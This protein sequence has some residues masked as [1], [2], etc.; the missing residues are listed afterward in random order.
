MAPMYFTN[1][2]HLLNYKIMK[3]YFPAA[4]VDAEYQVAC[5][6]SGVP[7]LFDKFSDC[8]ASFDSPLDWI[9]NW[10]MKYLPKEEDENIED[11]EN[12]QNIGEALVNYDLTSPMQQM[13][14][15]ALNLFNKYDYFNLMICLNSVDDNNYKVV[16]CALDIRM[17]LYR[18]E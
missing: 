17:G 1:N 18:G 2:T 11:Y 8:L 9:I 6:I 15:L 10:Q 13:G 3:S 5:Y 7:C 4:R 16:K 12:R 14:K